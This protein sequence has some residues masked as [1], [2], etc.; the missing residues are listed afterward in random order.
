MSQ[1]YTSRIVAKESMAED[2]T[3]VSFER[4][5]NFSFTA[6][7]HIQLV[8]EKLHY[9]D[10]KGRSRVFS[11]CSSPANKET[12][13][14]VFRETGSGFKKT[15]SELQ[16]GENVLVEG[17]FGFFTLPESKD[18]RHLFIAGGIGIAPFVSMLTQDRDVSN[19]AHITLLYA[20]RKE[21]LAA[22]IEELQELDKISDW[23]D[24]DMIYGHVEQKHLTKYIDSDTSL[25]H[26][27]WWIVGPPTMVTDTKYMIESL[28]VW[29]DKIHTEE[30]IGY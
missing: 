20:N 14:V 6:G 9:S 5:K 21:E 24:L 7:Q 10:P 2:T 28:G 17:P 4:P 26:L 15:L 1:I 19:G 16:V 11:I 13:S 8:V 25:S 29:A 18:A 22:F 27:H 12:L 3:Q 23:F 30:F